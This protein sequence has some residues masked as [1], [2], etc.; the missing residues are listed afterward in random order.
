MVIEN[1]L[2]PVW[3]KSVNFDG[4]GGITVDVDMPRGSKVPSNVEINGIPVYDCE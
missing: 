2:S 1:K 3:A 4:N